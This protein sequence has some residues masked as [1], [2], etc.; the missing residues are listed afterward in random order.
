[1]ASPTGAGGRTAV[2][3]ALITAF[4]SVLV[5]LVGIWPQVQNRNSTINDLKAQLASIGLG[6]SVLPGAAP[7]ESERYTISGQVRKAKSGTP[8]DAI[9]YAAPMDDARPLGE[10]GKFRFEKRAATAYMFVIV[11][12]APGGTGKRTHRVLVDNEHERS[13]GSD[14]DVQWTFKKEK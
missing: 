5:T 10:D 2:Y 1:M 8:V 4:G 9:I 6:P 3:T 12:D 14:L 11:A 13:T 7:P